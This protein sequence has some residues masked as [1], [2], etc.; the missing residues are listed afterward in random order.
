MDLQ[1]WAWAASGAL[2]VVLLLVDYL[3]AGRGSSTISF[4][5]AVTWSVVW[6]MLG[7]GF[8]LFLWAWQGRTAMEEYLAGF[9]IEKSLS[10]DNLFV[11]AMIFAYFA[12]PA[13]SQRRVLFWGIAGAILLRGV[14]IA[15]GAVL[16]DTFHY[17]IYVFGAILI[18]TGIR[19]ARHQSA[20]IHPERN[21]ALKLL[22]RVIP[23]RTEYHGDRLT[24]REGARRFGTPL[25]AALVLVAT[26][27]VVFAVDS[28]PAIFAVTREPFVVYAA[29]AFSLLGLAA[30]YFVLANMLGRF[31]YLNVGL[32]VVLVF[33][34]VK[35]TISDFY[36]IPIAVSLGVILL[37]LAAAVVASLLRPLPEEI[38]ALL[39]EESATPA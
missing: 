33:V 3:V 8:G 32:A 10:I 23:L 26:F 35:M 18:V 27:D 29:N 34:G 20:E 13:A 11:F 19:M 6:T 7:L 2:V 36:K 1:W 12:V 17:T 30:L 22:G 24:I 28:I 4:R 15:A 14:F 21:P 31:R 37:T 38:P 5:R 39:P 9:L 25:L 16:L